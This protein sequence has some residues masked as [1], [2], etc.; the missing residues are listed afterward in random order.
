MICRKIENADIEVS[1]IALGCWQFAGGQMWGDQDDRNSIAAVDAALDS[2]I[3][4]FDTAEGYGAGKS[5]EVLGRALKGKR[6]SAI[7]A[8]KA[9][10]PTYA[11]EELIGACEKSLERLQTDYI[12]IYQIHWPRDQMVEPAEIFEGVRRLREAG[13]VRFMSSSGFGIPSARWW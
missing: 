5:E 3:T 1:G 6:S 4:L 9:S 2:G 10:G 12:D 11:P 13:K 7:I 8:T